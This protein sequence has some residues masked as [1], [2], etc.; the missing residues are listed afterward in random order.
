MYRGHG[1]LSLLLF[2]PLMFLFRVFGVDMNLMLL[3]GFLTVVVS[4]MPDL[5]IPARRIRLRIRHRGITHTFL[6]GLV[7]GVLF[8]VMLG[9]VYG[10]LGWLMG[11]AAGFG[12]TA[13]HLAGDIFTCERP[14]V[15]PFYPFSDKEVAF[16]L[17]RASDTTANNTMLALGVIA[18][19]I[20]YIILYFL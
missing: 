19:T 4:F 11:F 7:I 5:D 17:F 2:S 13:S 15:K 12:G 6:F 16:S 3:T 8:S 9:L 14:N 18:F 10:S 1:G 20:S